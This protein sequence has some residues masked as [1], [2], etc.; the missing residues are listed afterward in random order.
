[1][2]SDLRSGPLKRATG[3]DAA[4][5]LAALVTAERHRNKLEKLDEASPISTIAC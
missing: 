4:D 1:M 3:R 2:F 5:D